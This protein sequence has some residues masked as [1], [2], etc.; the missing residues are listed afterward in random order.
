MAENKSQAY[1]RY[2]MELDLPLYFQPCWLD[3]VAGPEGWSAAMAFD[4]GGNITGIWVYCTAKY[5]GFPIVKMPPLTA[6][7]GPYLFY[8]PN[9]TAQESRYAFEKKVMN[10]LMDQLPPTAF[11]YQEWHPEIGNWLPAYWRGFQQT[12]HYTYLIDDSGDWN[13]VFDNFRGNVRTHIRK[14]EKEIRVLEADAVEDVFR[15]HEKSLQRQGKIPAAP[16]SVLQ[17]VDAAMRGR[18]QRLL[19]LAEDD[20]G[21]LHAGLY[22]VWDAHTAY[23]L[24]SGADP[25]LRGS[26]ALY[27]LVWNAL[28]FCGRK[29]L[30]FDFEGSMLEPLEEVFRGFGGR[31]R[32]HYKV[33]RAHNRLLKA[34]SALSGRGGY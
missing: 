16:L 33:F 5:W 8:P 7:S 1:R 29:G 20:A 9:M 17:R 4:K 15:M 14:A 28:Q 25:A 21:R 12:T 23:Y 30:A 22:L 26:G 2:C 13:A 10:E 31:M 19:L 34:V 27:L 6:Y 3:A 11:F 18:G 32:P 24:L